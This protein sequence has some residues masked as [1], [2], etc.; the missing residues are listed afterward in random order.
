[1]Q[2]AVYDDLLPVQRPPLHAAYARALAAR[3]KGQGDAATAELGRLAYHWHAAHDLGRA[4][5]GSVAAGQAAEAAYAQAEAAGHYERAL[6]LWDQAPEAAASSP[7]DR[8]SLLMRA[9]Q[10][11]SRS[12]AHGRALA[13]AN[14]V[15][16]ETDVTAE[17]IRA[18]ALLE[19]IARYQWLAGEVAAAMA[20]VERAVAIIPAEPPSA[21]RALALAAHGQ[22]LMLRS[23]H[24]AAQ[25]RCEE[26][27]A[28]ARS[29]G[30]RA[31]EGHALDSLGTSLGSRGHLEA[32]VASLKQAQTIAA[33]LGDPDELCRAYHN[34]GCIY[35]TSG[36]YDDAVHT[37]LECRALARRFGQMSA[38]GTVS[39]SVAAEA[40]LAL[41]RLHEAE[42]LFEELL[43]L[44]LEPR[45]HG[46]PA[47]CPEC[48]PAVAR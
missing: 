34:L 7:L 38:I 28:V 18:G 20:S 13:L 36:C 8:G 19:R 2:E 42:H 26:A 17:P 37:A 45:G 25:A 1:V 6:E 5:L 14:Q 48:A 21:E 30:A 22:M 40:L 31:V 23:R 9:A 15:L 35:V 39:S 10:A 46:V 16:T 41:G 27:A 47:A 11:A 33:E 32:A 29:A 24:Q 43:D 44:D 12:G 3:I 4:L